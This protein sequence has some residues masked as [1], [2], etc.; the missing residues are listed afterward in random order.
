MAKKT[1]QLAFLAAGLFLACV[2]EAG[3]ARALLVK[4]TYAVGSSVM[5]FY[6]YNSAAT[7]WIDGRTTYQSKAFLQFDIRVALPAEAKAQQLSKATLSVHT[8]TVASAGTVNVLAVAG[9]WKDNTLT[10]LNAPPLANV[11][12]TEQPYATAK[13]EKPKTWVSFDVTE[14]VR[15]WMDGTQ[16]NYGLA[17]VAA[18]TK[19]SVFFSSSEPGTYRVPAE[20]ELVYADTAE[21]GKPGPVGPE[22]PAGRQ[23]VPG[24]QGAAGFNGLNGA[25]GPAAPA[26][27]AGAQGLSGERGEPGPA[28]PA[29][30]PGAAA[31][32]GAGLPL[33]RILPR[34]DVSM[35]PFTQGEKP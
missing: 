6:N 21:G 1:G 19:T 26:G 28:G 16:P 4:D 14:L 10:G 31:P 2:P 27:P 9:T 17:L 20:L 32:G 13:V 18:D 5:S 24:L 33:Y 8:S 15:D 12:E 35:G 22:G 34:G 30:P 23:G 29:G 3:A 11:P 25:T 7:L